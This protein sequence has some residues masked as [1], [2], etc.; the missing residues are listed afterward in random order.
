MDGDSGHTLISN[1]GTSEHAHPDYEAFYR[2]IAAKA[3][4]EDDDLM[5]SL[6]RDG[7]PWGAVNAAI[8]Q[9]LPENIEDPRQKAYELAKPTLDA[10]FGQQDIGWHT[11]RHPERGTT[12]IR[13]GASEEH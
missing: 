5:R 11:F 6:D 12:W 9:A 2:K 8:K 7:A 1:D 4:E 3:V 10:I 13:K